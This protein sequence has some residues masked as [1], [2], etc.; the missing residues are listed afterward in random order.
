MEVWW[1]N[2][3]SVSK[4]NDLESKT[5]LS[6][7]TT[8]NKKKYETL[9][10]EFD[11]VVALRGAMSEIDIMNETPKFIDT[12]N[13]S[14]DFIRSLNYSKAC[15]SYKHILWVSVQTFKNLQ[16]PQNFILQL[17]TLSG[18][19][20]TQNIEIVMEE[21]KEKQS[22]NQEEKIENAKTF[23]IYSA[24]HQE[25]KTSSSSSQSMLVVPLHSYF[26]FCFPNTNHNNPPTIK[27]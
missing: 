17:L 10:W 6:M 26:S 20:S 11:G 27:K 23:Y 14:P 1:N 15:G 8:E 5:S 12:I 24:H 25:A 16:H 22:F 9:C 4:R 7:T 21:E 13:I 3:L 19:K 2:L 18:L